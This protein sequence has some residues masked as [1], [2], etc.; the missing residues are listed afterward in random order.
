[1]VEASYYFWQELW[2]RRGSSTVDISL[3]QGLNAVSMVAIG[4][5]TEGS[6]EDNTVEIRA[7]LGLAENSPEDNNV[8]EMAV[9]ML[10]ED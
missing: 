9:L 10:A 8:W 4:K 1:M 3:S 6:S 7:I 2:R 5:L